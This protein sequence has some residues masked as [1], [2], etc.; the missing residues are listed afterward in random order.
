MKVPKLTPGFAVGLHCDSDVEEV[1]PSSNC[2]RGSRQAVPGRGSC[3]GGRRVRRLHCAARLGVASPNS[4]RS[5]RSTTFK[6]ASTSQFT[7][8]A[9][10]AAPK[11]AL[12]V[13]PEIAPAGHRPPRAE[14]ALV[15]PGNTRNGSAKVRSGR[16]QRAS[17][18]LS[19][20]GLSARA[21]SAHQ[22]LTCR[23]MSERSEQSERSEFGDGPKERAAEGS[24]CTHR[25]PK[26]SADA[27]PGAPLPLD[28]GGHFMHWT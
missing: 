16:W 26:R 13:A 8:R 7:K 15:F 28:A 9:A 4:L 22:R 27:C 14:P 5:L 19:S 17:S 3:R 20:T 1:D 12:L 6:Q 25:P 10:R 2:L 11:P 23:R 21:R 24:R 18:A